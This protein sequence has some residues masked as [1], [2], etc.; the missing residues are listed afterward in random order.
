[1]KLYKRYVEVIARITR[2]GKI[3]PLYVVWE[4]G[5][6]YEIDRILEVRN[7]ASQVGG[8]GVM[9]R[10]RIQGQERNLYYE[11]NKWFLESVRP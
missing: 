4:N 6:K 3:T 1:M 10:C 11:I 9:Y 8:C 5:C 2:E 7:A